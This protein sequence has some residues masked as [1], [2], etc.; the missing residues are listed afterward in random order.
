MLE[1]KNKTVEKTVWLEYDPGN[2]VPSLKFSEKKV[3]LFLISLQRFFCFLLV[4]HYVRT[5]EN[6]TNKKG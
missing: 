2:E 6:S 3:I 5:Y 1:K 4:C